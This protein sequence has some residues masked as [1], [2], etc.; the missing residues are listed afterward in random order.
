L[1]GDVIPLANSAPRSDED[2]SRIATGSNTGRIAILRADPPL[3]RF[4]WF[5]R[6]GQSLGSLRIASDL[7]N[8]L[9]LSPDGRRAVVSRTVGRLNQQALRVDFD[10]GIAA[11]LT[12]PRGYNV[13]SC[14]SPDGRTVALSSVFGR[15][16]EEI[17]LMPADGSAPLRRLPTSAAQF[18]TPASWSPDGRD[19]VFSQLS[20]ASGRDLVVVDAERG[21]EPRPLATEPGSQTWA[22]ISPDGRWLVYDSDETGSFQLFVR[23]L[24]DGA[25]KLQLTAVGGSEPRL[26]RDGRE[27]VFIGNDRRSIYALPFE[28]GREPTPD[29]VRLL[30][31]TSFDVDSY[32]GWDVTPDGE[33]FLLLAPD[34][35]RREPSTTLIVDW[36]ALL[37]NR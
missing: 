19:L 4:E 31:R 13:P 23:G 8:G 18:K 35:R 2:A 5:G 16:N 37:E 20:S 14:W 11:A 3:R 21:G 29:A 30:F 9:V 32:G 17:A 15:G 27:L 36:P 7:Y 28:P 33:R 24:P 10:R 22:A 12:E 1:V 34:A 25:G 6:S 26:R